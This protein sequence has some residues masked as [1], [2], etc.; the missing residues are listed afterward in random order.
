MPLEI[1]RV[2]A[3]I[4]DVDGTLSDSDNVVVLSLSRVLR[5]L[6]FGLP[7][8]DPARF[9]RR[10]VMHAE[11]PGSLLYGLPDRFNLD[12][13]L[14]WLGDVINARLRLPRLEIP[15]SLVPE[16]AEALSTLQTR[17]PMAIA[18]VRGRRSLES[19]LER[20]GLARRFVC[21]A[22]A[23]TCRHTKPYPDP[24]LWAAAR[25]GVAP[26]RCAMIGDTPVDIRAGKA[27][28]MQTVGVLCGFGEAHN[29]R[30]AGADEILT[31][32]ADLPARLS[33]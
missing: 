2:Q 10:I 29:L 14:A 17:Y 33:G 22:H 23:Q 30:H 19:F 4:F 1:E 25:M 27:A 5:P 24:L 26:E 12:E 18:S 9:A 6:T 16:V 13:P 31:S 7:G 32:T 28:G 15:I 8:R 21:A 20:T 11:Q 3:L